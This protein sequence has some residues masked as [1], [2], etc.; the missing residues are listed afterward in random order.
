MDDNRLAHLGAW[1]EDSPNF[2]LIVHHNSKSSIGW[3]AWVLD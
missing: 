3:I 2:C 1:L